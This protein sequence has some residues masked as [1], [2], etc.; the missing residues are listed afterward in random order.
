MKSV[1]IDSYTII[2]FLFKEPGFEKLVSLLDRAIESN[3]ILLISSPSWSEVR[4]I[5]ERKSESVNWN[6]VKNK[7]LSLPI[8][9]VEVDQA[10][11][12]LAAEIKLSHD[13]SFTNCF[14][15]ALAKQKKLEIYTGDLEFQNLETDLKIVFLLEKPGI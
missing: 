13:L 8:Q 11:A 5:V 9:I 10:L 15:A 14:T 12:E 7:I 6:E 3:K 2:T 4:Y 1:V